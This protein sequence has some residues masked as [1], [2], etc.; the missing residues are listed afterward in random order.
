MKY[1][2][3]CGAQMKDEAKFC[4]SCGAGSEAGGPA[5]EPE[6]QPGGKP[7]G[8]GK[9][10]SPV[11]FIIICL[12]LV[13]AM[14]GGTAYFVWNRG[15]DKGTVA[16]EADGDG[17]DWGNG[18]DQEKE[19]E[20]DTEEE[21]SVA[22]KDTAASEQ[23]TS[24]EIEKAAAAD[25]TTTA[26]LALEETTAPPEG[27]SLSAMNEAAAGAAPEAAQAAYT[28]MYVVNCNEFITL[29]PGDSTSSGEICKIPLG[30]SVSYVS[31]AGNG[32][33][34]VIYNGQTGYALASYLSVTPENAPTAASGY[35]TMYVVNC[36][37]F[38][39][40]RSSDSTSAS[41]ICKIPLG[42]SV[43]YVSTAGNGF[44]KVIYN[45][46]TGYALASYLSY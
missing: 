26:D 40:M 27:D 23:E 21:T 12:V 8:D 41:E 36:K 4:P 1:C 5:R 28:T 33:Y 19:E 22:E 15:R 37:E 9:K 25:E 45:G 39:T 29:R 42:A 11:P 2:K 44:Y 46:F 16:Q 38:I 14:A 43:S 34:Q 17:K 32:F 24:A 20:K 18:G 35:E 3:K 30:A 31:T 10:K 6:R 7:S 13:A